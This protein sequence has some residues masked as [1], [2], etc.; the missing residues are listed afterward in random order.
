MDK[1]AKTFSLC[2]GVA[3]ATTATSF[4]MEPLFP[5]GDWRWV[6]VIVAAFIPAAVAYRRDIWSF[7]SGSSPTLP[8][9]EPDWTIFRHYSFLLDE[10]VDV[11]DFI[12]EF[13][14]YARR[15]KLRVWGRQ[16]SSASPHQIPYPL[17]EIPKEHWDNFTLGVLRCIGIDGVGEGRTEPRALQLGVHDYSHAFQ[18]L[19]INEAQAKLL[20]RVKGERLWLPKI[21]RRQ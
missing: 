20:W 12:R 7:F 4:L 10:S 9:P 13:E 15:G 18:D 5:I 8:E 14:G 3:I 1:A 19:Q 16:Y 2:F 17:R 21:F 11:S 6:V